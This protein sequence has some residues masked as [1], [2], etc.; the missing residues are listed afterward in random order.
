MVDNGWTGSTSIIAKNIRV[1][2]R[3][4]RGREEKWG[5]RKIIP[6]RGCVAKEELAVCVSLS[7]SPSLLPTENLYV[8]QDVGGG[9]E[10]EKEG[11]PRTGEPRGKRLPSGGRI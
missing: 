4:R 10:G 3:I 8:G 9:G 5:G 1:Y 11:T 6:K 2:I 7:A